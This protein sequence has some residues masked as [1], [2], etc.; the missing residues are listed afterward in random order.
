MSNHFYVLFITILP[1]KHYAQTISAIFTKTKKLLIY[2]IWYVQRLL[3]FFK[4][5]TSVKK[6][7]NE[8]FLWNLGLSYKTLWQ[9]FKFNTISNRFGQICF[10]GLEITKFL[11]FQT[12]INWLKFLLKLFHCLFISLHSMQQF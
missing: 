10:N 1:T 4:S 6:Y 12:S 8:I 11:K 9:T 3:E 7:F 5:W 2:I